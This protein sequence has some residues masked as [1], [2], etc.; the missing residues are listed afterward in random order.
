[1]ETSKDPDSV[2]PCLSCLIPGWVFL[3]PYPPM[4]LLPS[5]SHLLFLIFFLLFSPFFFSFPL[6]LLPSQPGVTPP[7]STVPLVTLPSPLLSIAVT[8]P[9]A[10]VA[11]PPS[12]LPV[13]VGVV[14]TIVSPP[15]PTPAPTSVPQ[16][17]ATVVPII[18]VVSAPPDT[19]M[20][21]PPQVLVIDG[22][23]HQKWMKWEFSQILKILELMHKVFFFFFLTPSP[24]LLIGPQKDVTKFLFFNLKC[25]S[26]SIVIW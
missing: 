22:R 24:F 20:E 9:S 7:T 26:W 12:P 2:C 15:P 25:T 4:T 10:A 23:T 5:F 13:P 17:L 11:P 14:P 1:M 16:A 8:M 18:S 3:L 19:P 6:F 21:A